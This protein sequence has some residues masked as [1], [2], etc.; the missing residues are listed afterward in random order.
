MKKS[1]IITLIAAL[2]LGIGAAVVLTQENENTPPTARIEPVGEIEG[3]VDAQG[4]PIKTSALSNVGIGT[5]VLLSGIAA[6]RDE[7]DKITSMVWELTPPAGSAA[8]LTEVDGGHAYFKA[9]VV[10]QY[11]VK[12]TVTD[13][14]GATGE[15]TLMVNAGTFVGVGNVAGA[16]P[17]PPQCATCHTD[18]AASWAETDHATMFARG[19]DGIVSS[20]YASYCISCHTVGYDE[21]ADNGGFDDVAAEV[22][23][24]FPET[25]QPGNWDAVPLEL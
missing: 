13:S 14:N 19:V 5:Y 24:T 18:K 20:H 23:W 3:V 4:N 10:G 22:G 9:D 17:H 25:L 2:L 11:A 8:T 15:A 6:D 1:L 7:G 12:L 21:T 16:T